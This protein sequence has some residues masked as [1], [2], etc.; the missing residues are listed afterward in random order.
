MCRT[1]FR[2]TTPRPRQ[3]MAVM[4]QCSSTQQTGLRQRGNRSGRSGRA[5]TGG[6]EQ[7]P[8]PLR[9]SNSRQLPPCQPPS[10][11]SG[12]RFARVSEGPS[13]QPNPPPQYLH[14]PVGR[15]HHLSGT[16][17]HSQ[18]AKMRKLW[19]PFG[20][21]PPPHLPS[22][23]LS[24]PLGARRV[25]ADHTRMRRMGI[26][27]PSQTTRRLTH[28]DNRSRTIRC[29]GTLVPILTHFCRSLVGVYGWLRVPR[30]TNC[31]ASPHALRPS[32]AISCRFL[33]CNRPQTPAPM[34]SRSFYDCFI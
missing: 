31:C 28:D 33:V 25:Q 2:S 32:R 1:C 18:H 15:I 21:H 22:S 30:R 9:S 5:S 12:R 34:T 13:T 27:N 24:L 26:P 19:Q 17:R 10:E 3:V 16:G 7:H 6:P 4:A 29:R 20:I 11:G 23:V 14:Y 8:G